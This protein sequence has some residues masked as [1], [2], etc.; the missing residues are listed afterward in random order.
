MLERRCSRAQCIEVF[1]RHLGHCATYETRFRSLDVWDKILANKLCVTR[2]PP[3]AGLFLV[4]RSARP[5][6]CDTP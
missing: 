3:A 5:P 6:M 2:A 4:G 1:F